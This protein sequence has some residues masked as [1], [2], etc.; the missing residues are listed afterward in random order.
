MKIIN[1]L[2]FALLL[3]LAACSQSSPSDTGTSANGE[4]AKA[5]NEVND[6]TSSSFISGKVQQAMEKAKQE[7]ATQ[8]ISVG[9]IRI[10]NDDSGN[11]SSRPKAEITPQ[12]ELLIGGNKIPATP[13]QQSLILDYREQVLGIAS[14][15]MDI[16]SQGAEL[17]VS[18]AKQAILGAFS[19]KSGDEI[20]ASIKPQSDRIEAAAMQLCQRLPALLEAQQKLAA[21]MPE[22]QPYA[23]MD[24]KD[25]DDCNKDKD[26]NGKKGF[27]VFAD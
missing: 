15:G 7:L 3:P 2:A 1:T 24:Q 22:F 17:G 9:D 12:G 18:A 26:E 16:G 19:G 27:A 20:E 8:N 25:I 5:M 23:T 4:V 13:A 14:A 10:G 6:K 11:R 21:A